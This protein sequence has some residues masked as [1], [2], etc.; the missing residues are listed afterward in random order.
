M[1]NRLREVRSRQGL[2]QAGLAARARV[3][4]ALVV[5]VEKWGHTPG[6]EV[7]QKIATALGVSPQD[8]WPAE[9]TL[10]GVPA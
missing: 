8:I 5:A 2:A 6:N 10:V 4:P 3:S 7:Q 9:S 1:S